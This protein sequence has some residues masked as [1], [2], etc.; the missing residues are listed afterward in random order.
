MFPCV[1]GTAACGKD[2]LMTL[3]LQTMNQNFTF[4]IVLFLLFLPLDANAQ[5]AVSDLPPAHASALEQFL[6]KNGGLEFLCAIFLS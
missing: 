1:L 4:L 3:G 5:K 6:A 2:T